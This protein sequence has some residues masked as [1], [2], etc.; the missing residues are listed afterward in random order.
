MNQLAASE[1]ISTLYN[2]TQL[3][4]GSTSKYQHF[5]L[6]T[7]KWLFT[8]LQTAPFS[9]KEAIELEP[10]KKTALYELLTQYIM[11]LTM[12]SDLTFPHDFLAGTS[13]VALGKSLLAYMREHRWPFPHLVLVQ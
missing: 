7:Q 4:V 1:V 10:S 9:I 12:N 3:M 5:S 13:E 11:F 8:R 6:D 2:F